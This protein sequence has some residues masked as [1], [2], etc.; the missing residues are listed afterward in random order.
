MKSKF[1]NLDLKDFFKSFQVAITTSIIPSI[2]V[3]IDSGR[4]PLLSEMKQIGV[5]GLAAWLGYLL[6]NLF[7]NSTD[8]FLKNERDS[9][10]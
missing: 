2:M 10:S 6:K 7:T 5:L 1:L 8:Q 4:L 3:I 9:I